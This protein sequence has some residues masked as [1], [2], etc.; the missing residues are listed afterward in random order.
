MWRTTAL[1][2]LAGIAL[3][4]ASPGATEERAPRRQPRPD[5]LLVLAVLAPER[6]IVA[7][8][9]TGRAT[10]RELPGG[11]LC[12]GPLLAV[13]DRLV[14]AGLRGGRPTALAAPLRRP[15]SRGRVATLQR[16][17]S[18]TASTGSSAPAD[19]GGVRSLGPAEILTASPAPGRL[20]LGGRPR[21]RSPIVLREVDSRGRPSGRRAAVPMRSWVV[22]VI[23][24]GVVL[25]HGARIVLL[26]PSARRDL[27]SGWPL[28]VAGSRVA[29]CPEGCRRIRVWNEG[30]TASFEPPAGIRPEPTDNAAFAP[31]GRR[32]ALA[33]K[34]RG[35]SR[36]AIVDL[37]SGRWHLVPGGRLAGYG[38]IA[39]SPSGGWLYFSRGSRVLASRAGAE[40]AVTLPIRTGGSVMDIASGPTST[41]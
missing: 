36:A 30:A 35:R 29:W 4:F 39:W 38:A 28:A 10:A 23:E 41:P 5:G 21:S 13:G 14:Y 18:A 34:A 15:G 3:A 11:T 32:L 27:G 26:T 40:P 19:R 9:R 17:A 31:D 20:W 22:G 6:A 25:G 7:D 8:P 12:H 1:A 2:T 37:E 24:E 33:V 16:R